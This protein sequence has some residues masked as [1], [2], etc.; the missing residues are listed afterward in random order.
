[1]QMSPSSSFTDSQKQIQHSFSSTSSGRVNTFPGKPKP[2]SKQT[3]DMPYH[4][5]FPSRNLLPRQPPNA[6]RLTVNII[7]IEKA[8]PWDFSQLL[9]IEQRTKSILF[10]LYNSRGSKD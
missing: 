10:Q 1:M 2:T 4:K 3:G 6:I 8:T 9:A 5:Q 7:G